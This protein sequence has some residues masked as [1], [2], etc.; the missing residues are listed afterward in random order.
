MRLLVSVKN[1]EEAMAALAGGAD[2]IDAKDPAAG[3]LGAVSLDV[4]RGIHST[5]AGLK[6][7]SAALGDA[8]DE[9]SIERDARAYALAGASLVKIGFAGISSRIRV[10]ALLDAA[11]RGAAGNAGVIA[12]A[13]ADADRADSPRPD[14]ILEAAA[15]ARVEGVLLDTADKHG[16][17]L[18]HLMAAATLRAWVTVAHEAGLLV[19]LAGKLAADDLEWVHD[20]GPDIAGVRGAACTGGRTGRIESRKVRELRE[21]AHALLVERWALVASQQL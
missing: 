15:A 8:L 5:V 6:P 16:P 14:L 9:R 21:Q 19:A 17:G 1:A 3:A 11:K 13:Y 20:A 4:L 7:V 10:T 2:F 12:V 18:R